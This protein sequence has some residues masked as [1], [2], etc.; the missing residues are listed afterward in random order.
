MRDT[1]Q[2]LMKDGVKD[3]EDENKPRH[4]WVKDHAGQ[5]VATVAQIKWS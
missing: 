2:K 4:A 5:V 3:Y 1:L